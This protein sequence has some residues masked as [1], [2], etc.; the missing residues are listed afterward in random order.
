M[1]GQLNSD[2]AHAKPRDVFLD[3]DHL[4]QVIHNPRI[5]PAPQPKLLRVNERTHTTTE[6]LMTTEGLHPGWIRATA[7]L[8]RGMERLHA[9]EIE[10]PT[11]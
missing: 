3:T 6:G 7:I 11:K 5:R 4:V 9:D 10:E 2:S 1:S 8:L